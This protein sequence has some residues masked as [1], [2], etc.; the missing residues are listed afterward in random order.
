MKKVWLWI[1]NNVTAVLFTVVGVLGAG[2]FWRY[3]KRRI[4]ELK[5]DVKVIKAQKEIAV[6]NAKREEITKQSNA[7]KEEIVKIDERL[8]A[9]KREIVE[10][11]E[12]AENLSD[13]QVEEEW[14]KLGY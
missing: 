6:F 11:H 5:D 9:N 8:K 1:K 4:G 2:I 3:R 12:Y 10:A 7:K 13:G 14:K